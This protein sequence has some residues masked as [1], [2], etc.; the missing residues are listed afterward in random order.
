MVDQNKYLKPCQ[1]RV[2]TA[3]RELDAA[4][5]LKIQRARPDLKTKKFIDPDRKPTFVSS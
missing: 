3:G 4:G 1:V 2:D 5:K